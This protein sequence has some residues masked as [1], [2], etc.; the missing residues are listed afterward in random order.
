MKNKGKNNRK[1]CAGQNAL[2]SCQITKIF[3]HQYLCKESMNRLD[4]L[5]SDSDQEQET[6]ETNTFNNKAC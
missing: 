4:I 2:M 1:K 5:H 6:S 3:D